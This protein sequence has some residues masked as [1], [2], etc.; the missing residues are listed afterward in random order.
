[1]VTQVA[2]R[3]LCA[4]LASPPLTAGVRTE[5]AL[6]SAADLLGCS[7]LRIV[8]LLPVPTR[9]IPAMSVAG[10]DFAV[11]LA[12]REAI[13]AGLLECDVALAAWGVS[14]LTGPAREHQRAQVRWLVAQASAL[15]V[16][17]VWTVGRRPRHP[18]RW[19]QYVSDGHGRTAAKGSTA[20][21]LRE[22]L[23]QR[24]WTS[25]LPTAQSG[26]LG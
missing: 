1:L 20:E 26:Q 2:P 3:V 22:V 18:S 7:T 5:N 9:D 11:W 17:E 14:A 21:R 23:V 8:N 6:R 4:V 12:G 16:C 15:P 25:L 24:S 13:A 10:A 19:H